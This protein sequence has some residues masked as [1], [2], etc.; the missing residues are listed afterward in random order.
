MMEAADIRAAM[1]QYLPPGHSAERAAELYGLLA[2][3][4]NGAIE[5]SAA[6]TALAANPLF[7]TLVEAMAQKPL[8]VGD[9]QFAIEATLPQGTAPGSAGTTSE[10]LS[11]GATLRI[12]GT[13]GGD[14][15]E[16]D[17][18]KRQQTFNVTIPLS[19]KA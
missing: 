19:P 4:A 15:A 16:R 13:G 14:Y 17:I 5:P 8:Q 3:I 1:E 9:K 11:T 2:D 12:V 7:P 10:A 6:G 18:D